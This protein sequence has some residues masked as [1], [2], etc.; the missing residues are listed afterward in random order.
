MS[1]SHNILQKTLYSM[2]LVLNEMNQTFESRSLVLDGIA[3][4]NIF[5]LIR[6][7]V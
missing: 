1:G 4:L 7:R 3:K 5:V 6:V 2:M